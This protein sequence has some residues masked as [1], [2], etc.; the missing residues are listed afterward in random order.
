LQAH[1]ETYCLGASHADCPV[2]Q[3]AGK[4]PLP[5]EFRAGESQ[6]VY[7]FGLTRT[8]LVLFIGILLIGM[9]GFQFFRQYVVIPPKMTPSQTIPTSIPPSATIIITPT[10]SPAPTSTFVP[11]TT[12]VPQVHALEVPINVGDH[13]FL[14]HRVGGGETFEILAKTYTT[15]PEVIRSLNYSMKSSLWANSL[16]VISPGL[17]MVDPALPAF[18]T[19]QVTT[20]GIS[21]DELAGK[22]TVDPTLLRLYNA[23]DDNCRL[24]VGDWLIIP[25]SK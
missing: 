21:I 22:L 12:I 23:C 7:H 9:V 6:R 5:P 15:T 16:I 4:K 2:Y 24:A 13:K 18:K 11:T 10:S 1:Q 19:Y 25:I 20:Q 14:I 8:L 17:Q 3:Q